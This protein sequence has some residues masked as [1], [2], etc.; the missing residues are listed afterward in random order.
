MIKEK[1]GTAWKRR[2]GDWVGDSGWEKSSVEGE[3]VIYKGE[4]G[5]IEDKENRGRRGIVGWG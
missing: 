5:R 3:Q 1:E 2:R 4:D